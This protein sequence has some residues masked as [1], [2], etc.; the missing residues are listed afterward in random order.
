MAAIAAQSNPYVGPRAYQAGERLYGRTRELAD[1]RYLLVAERLVLLYSPS[2]AGKT[3]L[4]QAALVPEL[5]K[6]RFRVRPAVRVGTI[7]AEGLPVGANR[8]TLSVLLALEQDRPAAAQLPPAGLAA[9]NLATYLDRR[10]AADGAADD[11][12]IFDQFEEVL[13]LDP[14]DLEAKAAFFAG[15]G[16]ALRDGRRWALFALREDYLAGLDP[17]RG[18]LPG[19]LATSFRLDLLGRSAACQ[20]IQAP[21]RAAGVDFTD[22]AATKLV[23]DLRQM[24]IQ[25]PDGTVL[26]QPGPWIEPVLLQVVCRGLWERLPPAARAITETDV[27]AVGDV[28]AALVRYYTM[29]VATVAGA[30]G[31]PERRIRDWCEEQLITVSGI[32]AQ[33]LRGAVESGGLL[34]AAVVRLVATHLVRAE[35]RRGATWYELA[36]DRLIEPVRTDNAHWR[37]A[38]HMPAL[39]LQVQQLVDRESYAE[40]LWLLQET[41]IQPGWTT[42]DRERLAAQLSKIKQ[43]QAERFEDRLDKLERDYLAAMVPLGSL[44]EMARVDEQLEKLRQIDDHR[45]LSAATARVTKLRELTLIERAYFNIAKCA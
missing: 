29:S 24:Q 15:L 43:L 21:A 33:V 26:V 25:Q 7:P 14:T 45:D 3:S 18:T 11:V 10:A 30:A 9:L 39:L 41:A 12:L 22:A 13:T 5:E 34:N 36:H 31:L 8:Y 27:A 28:D 23:D 17:Y 16:D 2:G 20:A 35:E 19:G 4:I 1:L 38:Y 37:D 40:A 44:E 42:S 32:R 6:R